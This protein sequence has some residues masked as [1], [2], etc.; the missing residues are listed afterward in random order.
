MSSTRYLPLR[1]GVCLILSSPSGAGKTTLARRL[2]EADPKLRHSISVTTR[3]PRAQEEEGVDYFFVS[4]DRF[5]ALRERGELL[6]SAEVFGNLYGTPA[7]PVKQALA[8]GEDMIFDV[9][10][11]GAASIASMLPAD[12]VRVF[13]LPPSA[14][15]LSRRIYARA[16][17]PEEVIEARLRAA[18]IEISHWL[19]YDYILVN[20]DIEECLG[21][22]RAVLEA[23]RHKRHRQPGLQNFVAELAS[24]PDDT[25]AG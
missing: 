12:T 21:V 6:E 5:E 2:L 11:Q 13:I 10:W 24:G 1:R 25:K 14:A 7:A 15:E 16:S 8:S 20:Y 23:E 18:A 17:E 4:R 19:E 22:L 9:D 3:A